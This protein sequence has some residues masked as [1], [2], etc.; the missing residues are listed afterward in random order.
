MIYQLPPETGVAFQ[1][2]PAKY[3]RDIVPG[4]TKSTVS[5]AEVTG[6]R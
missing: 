3:P 6:L 2:P 5:L 1:H 4:K